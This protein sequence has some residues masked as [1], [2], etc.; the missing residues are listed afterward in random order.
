ML[1]AMDRRS[2]VILIGF[3]LLNILPLAMSF[4]APPQS[5]YW[6]PALITTGALVPV[7]GLTLIAWGAYGLLRK[8]SHA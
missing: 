3:G 2:S 6:Y 8:R 7:V 1:S 4:L 5:A